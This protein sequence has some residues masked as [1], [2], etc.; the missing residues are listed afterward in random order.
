MSVETFLNVIGDICWRVVLASGV[1]MHEGKDTHEYA[2]PDWTSRSGHM[3]KY[4]NKEGDM[5]TTAVP[6]ETLS[7]NAAIWRDPCSAGRSADRR[8]PG[9]EAPVRKPLGPTKDPPGGAGGRQ[10]S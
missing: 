2:V 9:L 4:A 6:P 8:G 5:C 1:R 3:L 10:S 7:C